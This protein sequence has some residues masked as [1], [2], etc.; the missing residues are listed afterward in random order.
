MCSQVRLFQGRPRCLNSH[1]IFYR[2]HL[3]RLPHCHAL[4][5]GDNRFGVLIVHFR[6][7]PVAAGSRNSEPGTRDSEPGAGDGEEARALPLLDTRGTDKVPSRGLRVY[8]RAGDR[9]RGCP[10]RRSHHI[11]FHGLPLR[12]R[13]RCCLSCTPPPEPQV[14]G[15]CGHQGTHFCANYNHHSTKVKRN[16]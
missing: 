15:A 9:H 7:L 6:A 8:D 10:G 1:K 5:R 4:S 13:L 16:N 2:N 12:A 14:A 11:R 3:Q